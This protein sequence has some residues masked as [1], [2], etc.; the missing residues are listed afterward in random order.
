MR[1]TKF[2]LMLTVLNSNIAL[3]ELPLNE[4]K[5]MVAITQC[6]FIATLM[7]PSYRSQKDVDTAFNNAIDIF[8]VNNALMLELPYNPT[9]KELARDFA[10]H[11]QQ[12]TSDLYDDMFSSIQKQGLPWTPKSWYSIASQYWDVKNCSVIINK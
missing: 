3:A 10:M 8:K 6:A 9:E 1:L 11:Y 12:S 7:D 5:K 2:I 4:Y